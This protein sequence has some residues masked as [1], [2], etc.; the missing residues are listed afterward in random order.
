V[1]RL[2]SLLVD[3][4]QALSEG[5]AQDAVLACERVMLL[6]PDNVEAVQLVSVARLTLEEQRRALDAQLHRARELVAAGE[7]EAA[8]QLLADVILLGGD[9]DGARALLD[10]LRPE[11]AVTFTDASADERPRVQRPF[12]PQ[13][14]SR[15]PT[16]QIWCAAWATL[17][18]ATTAVVGV[19]FDGWVARLTATPVPLHEV[20]P[21]DR[22]LSPA[23]SGAGALAE[24]RSRLDSGDQRGALAALAR[25]GPDD[26]A[27][28]QASRLR[29]EA[30][31]AGPGEGRR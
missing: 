31:L 6:E 20:A 1:S 27:F 5:R 18:L 14:T 2:R 25:V 15:G 19:R 30:G 3:A 8:R 17:L 10:R 23:E 4:R 24:A 28:P 9:R 13:R 16:R 7:A 11:G 29:L 26:P 22:P 12:K 21:V